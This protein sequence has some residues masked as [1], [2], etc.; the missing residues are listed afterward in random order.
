MFVEI[1]EAL[2][3]AD[4]VAARFCMAAPSKLARVAWGFGP[5]GKSTEYWKDRHCGTL[6]P[7]P[8]ATFQILTNTQAVYDRPYLDP[9]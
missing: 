3:V 9:S 4:D 7:V 8:D 5:P 1:Q 6:R 2:R